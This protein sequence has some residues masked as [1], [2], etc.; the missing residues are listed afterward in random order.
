MRRPN[1]SSTEAT[2]AG[3]LSPVTLA[4]GAAVA[5]GVIIFGVMAGPG[6][7]NCVQRGDF[8]QCMSETF[9]G[10]QPI[11]AE[12]GQSAEEAAAVTE[13]VESQPAA[14]EDTAI[15]ISA[16]VLPAFGLVRVEPDGSAVI[17]GTATPSGEVRI[18]ANEQLLGT[19]TA[20][21]SGDWAFVTDTPLPIGGVE[22]RVLDVASDQFATTSVIVVV[23]DDRV[24]EPIV[25]ASEA[26]QASE[27][28]QGLEQPAEIAA[29]EVVEV[30]AA[31]AAPEEPTTEQPVAVEPAAEEPVAEEPVVAA[32]EPEVQVP[33]EDEPVIEVAAADVAEEPAA[34]EQPAAV[35]DEVIEVA[36][37]PEAAVPAEVPAAAEEVSAPAAM[38]AVIEPEAPIEVATVEDEDVAEPEAPVAAPVATPA[39]PLVAVV[40]PSIDAVE[41][42]GD[43]NFFAGAGTSG[44]AVR[45]YVDNRPIGTTTV[46][47]GRWLIEAI[48]VLTEAAQ[49]VRIDMLNVD[50]SVAGRAEVN[51]VLDIPAEPAPEQAPI[52]VAEEPAVVVE[53]P[54]VVP[55]QP[56]EEPV[57]VAEQPAQPVVEQPAA[58]ADEPVVAEEPAAVEQPV[59]VEQPIVVAED[60]VVEAPAEETTAPVV[61]E[62]EVAPVE[63]DTVPTLVGTVDGDRIVSGRVIIRRGDNLWSI[64][65]RVYGEGIRYTQIFEANADQIRNP[66]LIYPGQVFDLPGTAAV[67]G[68]SPEN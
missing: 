16:A 31:E 45:L 64:A 39:E 11:L 8:G 44:Y 53:E 28:L 10:G 4:I 7:V 38:E 24:G 6:T 5:T 51:F 18:F 37:A 47:D 61:A 66:D 30:A 68:E 32:A 25:V 41:I 15:S 52:V 43:R 35:A 33:A 1:I 12:A 26:G 55:A 67:L 14:S 27:I 46:A 9:F 29:D 34:I 42:D 21:A 22:L 36:D 3:P 62:A 19:E 23:Q 2:L 57:V 49:R 56:A 17:A 13:A 48:N 40:P 58:P 20:E 50:G 59:A 54:A 63:E 60:P 65:R